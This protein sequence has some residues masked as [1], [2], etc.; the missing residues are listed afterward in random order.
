[1]EKVVDKIK[2]K[3]SKNSAN[4]YYCNICDYTTSRKSNII[5]HYLSRKHLE[6]TTVDIGKLNSATKKYEII[7]DNVSHI[8]N[9]GK[10]YS[11]RQG[12]WKHRK[13][14]NDETCNELKNKVVD[15]DELIVTLLKQNADL[16]EIVK[17]G[18]H[19][20]TNN[21]NNNQSFNLNVYLNETCKNAMNITDFI[22]QLELNN[23]DLE[24]TG[25]LGYANGISRIF[26]N[27]L[28]QLNDNDRPIHCSDSKREIIYIKNNDVWNKETDDK[29]ILLKAIKHLGNKNIKQIFEWQKSHPDHNDAYSKVNDKYLK[30]ITSSMSGSTEEETNKNCLKI[31]KNIANAT[32]ITKN[33][34]NI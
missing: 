32:T 10:N 17:N 25:R 4:E 2:Q 12:L 20:T 16:L 19:N 13:T 26:I 9:C 8:C 30:I 21:I 11:T 23:N 33:N 28:N 3:L 1:M 14:C 22:D 29:S 24:E 27:G 6:L 15:K 5:N 18:T 34:K 7:D 31:I